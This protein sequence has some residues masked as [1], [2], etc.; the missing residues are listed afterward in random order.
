MYRLPAFII[1]FLLSLVAHAQTCPAPVPLAADVPLAF[2]DTT[3]GHADSAQSF[4]SHV[5]APD[6]T[7]AVHVPAA[8][9][10]RARVD[11]LGA[12]QPLLY[13]RTHCTE[14]LAC[15]P[16]YV[17][18]TELALELDG[19]GDYYLIV[20][21]A[22]GTSGA[23]DLEVLWTPPACGDGV[24]NAGEACD[25]GTLN[26]A[27]GSGCSSSCTV[28]PP[29]G[30]TCASAIPVTVA[31]GYTQLPLASTLGASND[32]DSARCTYYPE[33]TSGDVVYALTPART[34]TLVAALG[35]DDT[36]QDACESSLASPW[37]WDHLLYARRA[38]TDAA[39]E[40]ACADAG[41]A[42]VET[43]TLPVTKG[44]PVYVFVDGF[45]DAP[46][47]R[48]PASLEVVLL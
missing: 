46:W 19:P 44:V 33:G 48:G 5:A 20:D 36:G 30:D 4:C 24:L 21:G 16:S 3:V 13:L 11:T 28:A 37:C 18:H 31:R 34:G 45:W 26:G 10:L 42:D 43:I 1:V 25:L 23:F 29:A 8:G 39:S 22:Q 27:T 9:T 35:Y 41:A 12:L 47:S 7:Y 15:F 6:A 2:S 17:D 38:C 40:A 14:D 32:Y